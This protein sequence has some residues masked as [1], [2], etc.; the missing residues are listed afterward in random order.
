MS[1]KGG[2]MHARGMKPLSDTNRTGLVV[3]LRNE[4]PKS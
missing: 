3:K 1:Q 4:S 2:G